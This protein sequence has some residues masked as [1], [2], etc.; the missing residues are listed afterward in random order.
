M[1]VRKVGAKGQRGQTTTS[2]KVDLG[3]IVDRIATLMDAMRDWGWFPF[4]AAPDGFRYKTRA[5][6][7]AEYLNAATTAARRQELLAIRCGLRP[8]ETV[9]VQS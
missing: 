2:V 6:Y 3:A 4:P 5:E 8:Q 9:A 7:A 1:N